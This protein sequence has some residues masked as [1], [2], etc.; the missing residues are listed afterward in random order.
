MFSP[1]SPVSPS[2]QVL[3]GFTSPTYTIASTGSVTP[4]LKEYTVTAH[5]GTQ[6]AGV[7]DHSLSNPF[8]LQCTKPNK[9]RIPN[10]SVDQYGRVIGSVPKNTYRF[11]VRS[12]LAL[13]ADGNTGAV[14]VGKFTVELVIPAGAEVYASDQIK[15][16][17]LLL[18]GSVSNQLS[19]VVDVTAT[20]IL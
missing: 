15:A 2:S 18:L 7:H 12:G 13:T 19:G 8:T 5:G 1:S 11:S 17:L 4:T 14:D 9:L 20:G 16:A 10:Y 6:P 3:T